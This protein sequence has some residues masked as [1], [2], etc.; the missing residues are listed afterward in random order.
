M[1]PGECYRPRP[2]RSSPTIVPAGTRLP[3]AG[4]CRVPKHSP[5]MRCDSGSR[6]ARVIHCFPT[7]YWLAV[8]HFCGRTSTSPALRIDDVKRERRVVRAFGR[9]AGGNDQFVHSLQFG[10]HFNLVH[11]SGEAEWDFK[12]GQRRCRRIDALARRFEPAGNF[13]QVEGLELVRIEAG[14]ANAAAFRA[15][16][17]EVGRRHEKRP[18]ICIQRE[19]RLV[20]FLLQGQSDTHSPAVPRCRDGSRRSAGRKPN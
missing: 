5:K 7:W 8:N 12:L 19:A 20:R 17:S 4:S 16:D 13:D 2:I 18:A 11:A 15:P 10:R 3:P 9:I 6:A 1:T 14:N